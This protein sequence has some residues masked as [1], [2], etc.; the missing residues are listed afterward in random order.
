MEQRKNRKPIIIG[1]IIVLAW[2]AAYAVF[3]YHVAQRPLHC[4]AVYCKEIDD[5]PVPAP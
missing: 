4:N 2:L 5:G 1:T 3:L